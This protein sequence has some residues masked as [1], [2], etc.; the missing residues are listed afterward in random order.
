LFDFAA[1]ACSRVD[2]GF[3]H[4]SSRG[5]DGVHQQ[6]AKG[7]GNAS[8]GLSRL[9]NEIAESERGSRTRGPRF[10]RPEAGGAREGDLCPRENSLDFQSYEIDMARQIGEADR[11]STTKLPHEFSDPFLHAQSEGHRLRFQRV[12]VLPLRIGGH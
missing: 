6:F 4:P 2:I 11:G 5:L 12:I 9:G 1:L 10:S 7:E 3:R 8:A